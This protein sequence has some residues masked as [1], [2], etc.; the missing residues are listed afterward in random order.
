MSATASSHFF[1]F[2]R[3]GLAVVTFP[4]DLLQLPVELRQL[5]FD[6]PDGGLDRRRGLFERRVINDN[7]HVAHGLGPFFALR[8]VSG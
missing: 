5:L 4:V 3:Y 7:G 8:P 1:L 2:A 6:R